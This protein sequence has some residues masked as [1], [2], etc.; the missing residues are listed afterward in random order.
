MG[1]TGLILCV[2]GCAKREDVIKI[3]FAA[4]LTGDQAAI[5]QDLA[6]GVQMA[7]DEANDR[8]GI[9]G[10]KVVLVKMDDEHKPEIARNV[11]T[12]LASD[13]QVV[14]VV[15][16]LNSGATIPA[17]E[18]YY[19]RGLLM[20]TPC[21][22][23][24]EVTGKGYRNVFRA[25]TTDEVQ[26]QAGA[27]YAV[28]I[29]KHQ[30]VAVV[31]DNSQYGKGLAEFFR[32]RTL[33]LKA[34]V[35]AF[36][37]ITQISEG[38]QDYGAVITKIKSGKPE[39]V[40]F[41]G[42]YPEAILLV[43]QMRDLGVKAQFMGG[44]GLFSE[45][46]FIPQAGKAGEGTVLSFLT[47]PFKQAAPEF[48]R[49]F[50]AKYERIEAYAPYGYDAANLVVQ[51]VLRAGGTDRKKII[52]SMHATKDYQGVMGTINFNDQGDRKERAIY[53]YKVQDG[54]YCWQPG[55]PD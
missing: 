42:M 40:Y 41:G 29:L 25:C 21:A 4:P 2:A 45:S 22:T 46:Q 12:K 55:L 36:E 7:I 13:A 3:G 1:L 44:D 8:G 27:D 30:R 35:V 6:N 14:A 26:G 20:I 34:Q 18:V 54:A 48:Y 38:G 50:T 32:K 43:K 16:H 5:G 19:D 17:S 23:N 24:P 28:K 37:A 31:H 49:K 51:A 52:E 39:V 10:K 9:F 33:E 11:A 15:G 47:P 53:F